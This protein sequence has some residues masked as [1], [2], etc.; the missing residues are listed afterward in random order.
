MNFKFIRTEQQGKRKEEILIDTEIENIDEA[1][2][3]VNSWLKEKQNRK[4]HDI[5]VDSISKEDFEEDYYNEYTGLIAIYNF[6]SSYDEYLWYA[7]IY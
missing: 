5:L 1:V 4:Y 2:D 7:I 6:S 3:M